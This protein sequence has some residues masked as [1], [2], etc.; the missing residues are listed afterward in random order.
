M[1]SSIANSL[2]ARRD[3]FSEQLLNEVH[4]GIHAAYH[5]AEQT[6][7][8]RLWIR[9]GGEEGVRWVGGGRRDSTSLLRVHNIA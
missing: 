2:Y 3:D 6:G 5:Q 8:S 7:R 1:A 9:Y 4:V